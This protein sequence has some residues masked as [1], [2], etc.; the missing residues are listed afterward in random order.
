MVPSPSRLQVWA[1][2]VSQLTPYAILRGHTGPITSVACDHWRTG[3]FS[4][5]VQD[6]TVRWWRV[7]SSS[8]ITSYKIA[9]NDAL[10]PE[11][12]ESGTGAETVLKENGSTVAMLMIQEIFP[13]SRDK[14]LFC[15]KGPRIAVLSIRSQAQ[16]LHTAA[17]PVISVRYILGRK[18]KL[19]DGEEE[20]KDDFAADDDDDDDSEEE[21]E[22]EKKSGDGAK[23]GKKAGTIGRGDDAVSRA[24]KSADGGARSGTA[25]SASVGGDDYRRRKSLAGGIESSHHGKGGMDPSAAKRTSLPGVNGAAGG[26]GGGGGDARRSSAAATSETATLA[27]PAPKTGAV[28]KSLALTTASQYFRTGK[29]YVVVLC[30]NSCMELIDPQSGMLLHV[31]SASVSR[32]L[33]FKALRGDPE[34]SGAVAKR[35]RRRRR[36]PKWKDLSLAER[37]ER[38]VKIIIRRCVRERG[39]GAKKKKPLK[40]V[41][42]KKHFAPSTECQR[43]G[44][45]MGD[46]SGGSARAAAGDGPCRV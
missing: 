29:P 23:H 44:R 16:L 17:S 24:S 41:V 1:V 37:R 6:G 27:V 28:P 20:E 4:F 25:T 32:E 45:A 18:K 3:L 19:Q 26:E 12:E 15:W 10:V 7:D 13:E 42:S 30:D 21:E 9:N 34:G 11:T 40:D 39:E 35:R 22:G 43:C 31:I 8:Q 14:F 5:S 2:R 46:R 38:M 36:G 33:H